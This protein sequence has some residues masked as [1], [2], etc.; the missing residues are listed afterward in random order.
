M[1]YPWK[2]REELKQTKEY[3]ERIRE[4]KKCLFYVLALIC[5]ALSVIY[6]VKVA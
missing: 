5:I 3:K 2:A 1:M 6:L 4:R